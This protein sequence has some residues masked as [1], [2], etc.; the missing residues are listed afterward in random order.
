MDETLRNVLL[1]LLQ[2]AIQKEQVDMMRQPP[3]EKEPDYP[4][5]SKGDYLRQLMPPKVHQLWPASTGSSGGDFG[6][7]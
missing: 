5:G 3:E 1:I 6:G 2:Y 7:V 4:V